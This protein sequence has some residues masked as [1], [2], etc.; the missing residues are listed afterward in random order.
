[1]SP[2]QQ[3]LLGVGP[4]GDKYWWQKCDLSDYANTTGWS[5]Y[6][7]TIIADDDENSYFFAQSSSNQRPHIFGFDKDGA[8]IVKSYGSDWVNSGTN[9]PSN[10]RFYNTAQSG[11]IFDNKLYFAGQGLNTIGGDAS[12]TIIDLVNVASGQTPSGYNQHQFAVS[13]DSKNHGPAFLVGRM[14]SGLTHSVDFDGSN[15]YLSIGSS[16]DYDYGTGDFCIEGW[17][18]ADSLASNGYHKRLFLNGSSNT[19]SLQIFVRKDNNKIYFNVTGSPLV[20]SSEPMVIG[21]WTHIA[22]VRYS[23]VITLYVNGV[24]VDSANYSSDI[25]H[26]SSSFYIGTHLEDS[27]ASWNGKI[28]NF[29]VVKGSAV[30]TSNFAPSVEPLTNITNTKLL[31]CNGSS[32]TSSTVTPATI[33]ANGNPTVAQD[34]PLSSSYLCGGDMINKALN[35]NTT[36]C[37]YFFKSSVEL[38]L[39]NYATANV[40]YA[41]RE[42]PNST[43]FTSGGYEA[44]AITSDGLYAYLVGLCGSNTTQGGGGNTSGGSW[45]GVVDA[46]LLKINYL[47]GA[48]ITRACFPT[49]GPSAGTSMFFSIAIDSSGNIYCAG[50]T[51]QSY[52]GNK[53]YIIKLNSSMV[54]QWQKYISDITYIQK[55]VVDSSGNVYGVT[56]GGGQYGYILKITSSGTIDWSTKITINGFTDRS[57]FIRSLE[58]K[59][60]NENLYTS[61]TYIMN[62]SS[63]SPSTT[64]RTQFACIKYPNTGNVTG[65]Y[66][67]LVFTAGSLSSSNA[68]MGT[69]TGNYTDSDE[70]QQDIKKWPNTNYGNGNP[71][72]TK[73]NL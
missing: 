14:G 19:D 40:A 39:A 10:K 61:F 28:S 17:Y 24:S 71:T 31:C 56:T 29:R 58:I 36:R 67:D 35:P 3:M 34:C 15:D 32:T 1:M 59:G 18:L 41:K 44:A 11:F 69:R 70:R 22:V 21:Q 47:T 64:Y 5:G 57:P 55:I 52:S 30:Y 63:T 43:Y 73:T 60:E 50:K 6:G 27:N 65:T 37:P 26:Q 4:S 2:I 16:S 9:I 38:G 33:T 49:V 20:N 25:D 23:S 12:S 66:G 62:P 54:V 68:T 72:I 53:A 51:K 48:L 45:G 13:G 42:D 7:S 46:Y 8:N